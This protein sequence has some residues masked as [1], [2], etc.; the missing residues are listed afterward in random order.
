MVQNNK[1]KILFICTHNSARSQMAEGIANSMFGDSF[2]AY[3]AGTSP[4]SVNPYAI[5]AMKD[6]GI[7]IENN[8]S[9][10]VNEFNDLNFDYAVTVC[11]SARESC[12]VFT[13]AKK[14]IHKSFNDPSSTT[15]NSEEILEEFKSVR[16]QIKTWIEEEF[17]KC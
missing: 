13:G 15:G 14:V 10:S 7:N 16:D 11:D 17:I 5:S 9:K 4:S 8:R 12:P 1:I 6:I 3:S 2:E